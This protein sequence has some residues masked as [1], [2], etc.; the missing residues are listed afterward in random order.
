MA[1]PVRLD[2]AHSLTPVRPVV[3]A[4]HTVAVEPFT[5]S[6]RLQAHVTGSA[7]WAVVER[8]AGRLVKV[9]ATGDD[10]AALSV[11][12]R[13]VA[14]AYGATFLTAG[15]HLAHPSA[16][17]VRGASGE[18]AENAECAFDPE[19]HTGPA[20]AESTEQEAARVQVAREV[21]ETCPV[22]GL[23]LPYALAN[24]PACGVWGGFTA[25]ELGMLAEALPVLGEVA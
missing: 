13:G 15:T 24:P 6:L 19:L 8:Y 1:N 16:L 21:C 3:A 20:H 5:P 25:G 17:A 18:L 4:R 14:G 11:Q 7:T 9:C 23:C 10:P 22:R 2:T 12:G